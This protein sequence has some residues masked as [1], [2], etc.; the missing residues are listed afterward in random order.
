MRCV[1]VAPPP[2]TAS[3][4]PSPRVSYTFSLFLRDRQIVLR[5]GRGG[6]ESDQVRVEGWI[7]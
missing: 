3:P 1:R 6:A 7:F 4:S 5:V 2:F